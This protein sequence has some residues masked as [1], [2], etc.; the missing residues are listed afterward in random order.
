MTNNNQ[1]IHCPKCKASI[2]VDELGEYVKANPET[3]KQA[4][5]EAIQLWGEAAYDRNYLI[6]NIV[7]CPKCYKVSHFKGLG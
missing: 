2:T 6:Q 3:K 1:V 7:F 5:E 4:I